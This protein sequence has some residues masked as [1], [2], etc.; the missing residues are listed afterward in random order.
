MPLTHAPLLLGSDTYSHSTN[1][2]ALRVEGGGSLLDRCHATL[3]VG[4]VEEDTAFLVVL[5]A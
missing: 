4:N 1:K 5:V 3:W 2:Q